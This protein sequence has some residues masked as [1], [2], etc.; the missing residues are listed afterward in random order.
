MNSPCRKKCC[1]PLSA[2]RVVR[3]SPVI[4]VAY[5]IMPLFALANAGVSLDG[6]N[7]A[8]EG[9]LTVMLGVSL[10]LLMGKPLGVLVSSWTLV[11][12][13]WCRLPEG[14]T[15]SWMWLI[16]CLAGIGF[17]MSIFIA[18]LAFNDD[19]LLSAAKLGVLLASA[20]AGVIGLVFG[21]IIVLRMK[22][23]EGL[24]GTRPS[25]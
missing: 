16:G 14:M 6:V 9:S 24:P 1:H 15:W 19:S 22:V 13:G 18:S 12:L 21:R 2:P 7:L 11:R 10:A 4:W 23:A 20:V 8:N 5:V 3:S 25:E 17:T